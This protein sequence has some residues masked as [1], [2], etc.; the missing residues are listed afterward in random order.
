MT[1]YRYLVHYSAYGGH[2][3]CEVTAPHPIA[4]MDD[5]EQAEQVIS[6]RFGHRYVRVEH[7]TLLG[8]GDG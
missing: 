8:T 1:T 3:R 2:G 6:S 4:S 7:Y 5:I